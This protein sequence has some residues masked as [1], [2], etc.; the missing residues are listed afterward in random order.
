MGPSIN[1][2]PDEILGPIIEECDTKELLALARCC[3]PLSR[4][5]L[6][7]L[8][9]HVYYRHVGRDERVFEQF[10]DTDSSCMSDSD[11][12]ADERSH[13]QHHWKCG[14]CPRK[15]SD[16]VFSHEEVQPFSTSVTDL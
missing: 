9:R 15:C 7:K 13:A 5:A 4:I 3:K 10:S 16:A 11:G 14:L 6:T 12:P 8:Y 1:D 2:L